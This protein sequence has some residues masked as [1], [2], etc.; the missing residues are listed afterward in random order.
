MSSLSLAPS[1]WWRWKSSCR[2]GSFFTFSDW[3][4]NR[5]PSEWDH[6]ITASVLLYLHYFDLDLMGVDS[7]LLLIRVCQ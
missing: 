5:C 4:H 1:C 3:P 7:V 2:I 6:D